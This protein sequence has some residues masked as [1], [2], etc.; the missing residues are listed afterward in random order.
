MLFSGTSELFSDEYKPAI[1]PQYSDINSSMGSPLDNP[2][3][4]EIPATDHGKLYIFAERVR[5]VELSKMLYEKL[6][7]HKVGTGSIER[8]AEKTNKEH[9]DLQRKQSL[10]REERGEDKVKENKD[11]AKGEELS[12]ARDE[13]KVVDL[14]SLKV[15]YLSEELKRE[16]NIYMVEKEKVKK[17]FDQQGK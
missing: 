14:L 3:T 7:V 13:R 5:K 6:V 16:G 4:G 9:V 8:Q 11:K 10:M 2:K 12:C 15:K 1:S 17:R